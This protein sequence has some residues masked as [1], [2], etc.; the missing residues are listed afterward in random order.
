MSFTELNSVEH[1]IIYQL[2]GVNLNNENFSEIPLKPFGAEWQFQSSDQL[3][4]DENEVLIESLIKDA[5]IRLNP[6]ISANPELAEEVIHKLR[7]IL[8]SVNEVGLVK[9]NKE[10]FLADR[11]KDYAIR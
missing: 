5:L 11:S 3:E 10:F 2:S 1:Y 9:A 4:R 7:T 8:I 6:E